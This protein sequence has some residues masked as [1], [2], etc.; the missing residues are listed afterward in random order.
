MWAL[1][2]ALILMFKESQGFEWNDVTDLVTS[3][4]L[5]V[6]SIPEQTN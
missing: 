5:L 3:S 4:F 1:K 6:S 2:Q